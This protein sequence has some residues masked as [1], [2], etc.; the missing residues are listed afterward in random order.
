MLCFIKSNE[1]TRQYARFQQSPRF[2]NHVHKVWELLE[3]LRT[4][5]PI[6]VR[7]CNHPLAGKWSGWN[8]AHIA[9]NLI[10]IWR[11]AEVREAPCIVLGALGTHAELGLE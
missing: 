4:E 2:S 8:D 11:R 5:A 9:P 3:L 6:P 10:L 1:F 7:F